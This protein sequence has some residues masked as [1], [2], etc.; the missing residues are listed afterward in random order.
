MRNHRTAYVRIYP[1]EI[2]SKDS[3]DGELGEEESNSNNVSDNENN[4]TSADAVIVKKFT[5]SGRPVKAP[6]RLD[7]LNNEISI[8][9]ELEAILFQLD[10]DRN[11]LWM[12]YQLDGDFL[13]HDTSHQD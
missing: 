11:F 3:V 7:I 12:V 5:S 6:T 8:I 1:L 4:E 10:V 9:L 2:Y 13:A